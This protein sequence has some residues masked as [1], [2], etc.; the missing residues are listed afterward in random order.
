MAFFLGEDVVDIDQPKNFVP[1]ALWR[2]DSRLTVYFK[3]EHTIPSDATVAEWR[4]EI[5]NKGF[6]PL[7]WVISPDQV[8][9]YNGFGRP[10]SESD[11]VDHR[12]RIFKTIKEELNKLDAFAGRLAMETGN[13]W[14]WESQVNRDSSVDRQ[15]LSDI[16]LLERNLVRA[17]L[18]RTSAQALIGRS[19][20]TQYLIDRE[21]VTRDFLKQLFGHSTLAGVLRDSHKAKKLFEWL[22]NTFNGDIFQSNTI[23]LFEIQ[24]LHRIADFLDAVDPETGQTT[25]FPYQF[26]VIPVELISS[27]YEQFARSSPSSNEPDSEV[28]V[29][30]TRLSLVSLIMDEV[31][32]GLSGYET[33]LD[34]SC[35]SGVFL[36]EALRRLVALRSDSNIPRRETIRNTLYQQIY[37]FDISESAVQVAAFSLYL[38]ALEL[39]PDPSPPESLKFEPLIG[40]TLFV[41]DAW[42]SDDELMEK[43]ALVDNGELKKFDLIVGNPPW[44]FPG[45]E[46]RAAQNV[47]YNSETPRSPRGVSLNFVSQAMK[48]ASSTTRLGVV[49]SAVQFFSRSTTGRNVLRRIIN[50]LSPVTLVNLSFQSDWLFSNSKYPAM[51]LLARHRSVDPNDITTV[52]VPWSRTGA[53]THTFEISRDDINT[54]PRSIWHENPEYL[55]A[56]F[57]GFRSDL[58]LL[59]KLISKHEN[60]ANQLAE[61][62]TNICAG[63]KLGNRSKDSSFLHG[64]PLLKKGDLQPFG[65]PNNLSS[66]NI[67]GAERPRNRD[68]YRAPLLLIREFL[69]SSGRLTTAVAK[70]DIVFTDAYFGASFPNSSWRIAE[71]LAAILSSSLASWFF[72][73]DWFGFRVVV[74]KGATSRY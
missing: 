12:L 57:F 60:L 69:K 20:F 4:R 10:N 18:D 29:F 44:S 67:H 62:N 59:E 71:M 24:H 72:S 66:F 34:L 36:V 1:D 68:N 43:I 26:D 39:D 58:K 21:I 9:I 15:L 19:I 14:Q 65:V 22:R 16:N 64:L 25:F 17:D 63:L 53:L 45:K 27:I 56:A 5:W 42:S 48:F 51:V 73:D 52:Q 61:L 13:F 28:D 37:G 74:T 41:L 11:A 38:A 70:R 3:H 30:Y 46:A 35:G 49:L 40:K 7:L 6:A 50:D 32:D 23:Y 8:E 33:V 2:G 54:L 31:T 47:R 55:K